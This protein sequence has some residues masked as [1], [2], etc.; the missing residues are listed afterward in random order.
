MCACL[1][2]WCGCL[3]VYVRV[4]CVHAFECMCECVR[5]CTINSDIERPG[6]RFDAETL[7]RRIITS[8]FGFQGA[9][10]LSCQQSLYVGEFDGPFVFH[11]PVRTALAP[12]QGGALLVSRHYENKLAAGFARPMIRKL[13]ALAAKL[14]NSLCDPSLRV[15]CLFAFFL[16]SS[17]GRGIFS[18][19]GLAWRGLFRCICSLHSSWRCL[20]GYREKGENGLLSQLLA[21]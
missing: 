14:Q 13:F 10:L 3:C 17:F 9:C 19:I 2:E 11:R 5:V 21:F 20:I 7:A 8:F 16:G 12:A 6:C 18:I 4:C 1:S 15:V